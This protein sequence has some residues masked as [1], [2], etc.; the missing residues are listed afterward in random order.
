MKLKDL[1]IGQTIAG[2]DQYGNQVQ[3]VVLAIDEKAGTADIADL[4]DV[5]V[6]QVL[7]EKCKPVK[8]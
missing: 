2:P 4:D 7:V 5:P 1:K 3:G 6:C 8:D